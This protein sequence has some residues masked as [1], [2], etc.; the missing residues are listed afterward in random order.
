MEK[1]QANQVV[2]VKETH[3]A[4]GIQLKKGMLGYIYEG[5]TFGALGADEVAVTFPFLQTQFLGV[6]QD[7]IEPFRGSIAEISAQAVAHE[8]LE[9]RLRT[10]QQKY[11]DSQNLRM[12]NVLTQLR[13]TFHV[14]S[15][16][17]LVGWDPQEAAEDFAESETFLKLKAVK[18]YEVN[19]SKAN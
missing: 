14:R 12:I 9:Q 18:P 5:E 4:N 6:S 1:F 13:Q 15:M 19:V 11:Q 2:R 17:E 10:I 3:D 8:R 16:V 7:K